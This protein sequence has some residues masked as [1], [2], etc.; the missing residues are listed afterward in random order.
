MTG[1]KVNS[2]TSFAESPIS[3]VTQE[4][5]TLTGNKVGESDNPSITNTQE[6]GVD[7]GDIVKQIG[8][9]LIVMQDGRLFSIN[10]APNGEPGLQY[11]D[12]ENVYQTEEEDTW[13]DE[14]LVFGR[15]MIVIGYSYDAEA[16]VFA[17]LQLEDDGQI[18]FRD[19]FF[20]PAQDY[21][22]EDNYTTRLVDGQLALHT[23]FYLVDADNYSDLSAPVLSRSLAN[24][25]TK[26]LDGRTVY[27]PL[28]DLND[29]LLHTVTLCPLRELGN[30]DAAI[31]E[32]RTTA[33]IAGDNYE[34]YASQDSV[35][36]W[37]NKITNAWWQ[38]SE[39]SKDNT[40][41]LYR[42]PYDGT[43][44]L[45][46]VQG[47]PV[48]Q[49]SLAA[50]S[51][52]FRAFVFLPEDEEAGREETSYHLMQLPLDKIGKRPADIAQSDYVTLPTPEDGIDIK[53]R[54]TGTHFI[55]TRDND[56][57]AYWED[58]KTDPKVS[59]LAFIPLDDPAN[60][61]FI[62]LEHNVIRLERARD[63]VVATGYRDA[64]GLRLSS[65]DLRSEAPRLAGS[66]TLGG[67]YES[68]NRSH[69]FN[70]SIGAEG[71]GL[72]GLPTVRQRWEAGRFVW[73]SDNS[74]I[75]FLQV[76]KDTSLGYVGSLQGADGEPHE[77]YSCEVSC[78]DW[79]GNSRPIFTMGRVFALSGTSLVEGEVT[80]RLV[81]EIRR[82]DLTEP[83]GK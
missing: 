40:A 45:T 10:L 43:P 14:M 13:Y 42:I 78:V 58:G 24:R 35:W 12:R 51:D 48:D 62:D 53:N 8:T 65:L 34:Y 81:R 55:Y 56:F 49:F 63:H 32:C 3:T 77:D 52:V 76:N 68:E 73:R 16:T 79:Y 23:S 75:S 21:F 64:R 7:E 36:L 37:V 27:R 6:V 28:Q 2:D 29:P 26:Q 80:D 31:P 20:L 41:L 22:D 33:F 39:A 54:F 1:T 11:V 83:L 5:V 19:R 60:P 30:A 50:A 74:D 17:V 15:Q 71:D 9:Y 66:V 47:E 67:R 69:A 4:T 25:D 46:R 82:V 38:D 70:S 57:W 72:I 18:T 44:G 59:Q 61:S